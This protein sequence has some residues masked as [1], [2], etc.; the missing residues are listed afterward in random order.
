MRTA[1]P[2]T[3]SPVLWGLRRH[4]AVVAASVLLMTFALPWALRSG[5]PDYQASALVV[6][7]APGIPEE[8]LPRYAEAVF[9]SGPVVQRVAAVLEV[10]PDPDELVPDKISLGTA[11][12][13]IV[14]TVNGFDS[15]P[16]LARRLA[17]EAAAAYLVELNKPGPELG[18]FTL[19]SSAAPPLQPVDRGPG[20]VLSA[21]IGALAGAALGLGLVLLLL[22]ARR[23]VLTEQDYED[24]VGAPVLGRLRLP[25]RVP[26]E[27][28]PRAVL[29]IAPLVHSLSRLDHPVVRVIASG[30]DADHR[31]AVAR[32]IHRVRWQR[33]DGTP[34]TPGGDVVDVSS[35]VDPAPEPSVAPTLLVVREGT[36]ERAVLSTLGQ[37]PTHDVVGVVVVKVERGTLSATT[38]TPLHP[39]SSAHP[40]VGP[41][42]EPGDADEALV[43]VP[44]QTQDDR[45]SEQALRS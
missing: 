8:A 9:A 18:V 40:P 38:K 16:E 11:Q 43:A 13:S 4:W 37:Y 23:P 41:D 26:P 17:D 6:A 29:G 20:T 25:A 10:P 36:P 7:Q 42:D 1:G 32:L 31:A 28:E 2:G 3:S 30:R 14:L 5:A 45:P 34:V 44:D 12:N 21:C 39:A 19:Q 15:D 33:P 27:L 35:P 22:H 24:V